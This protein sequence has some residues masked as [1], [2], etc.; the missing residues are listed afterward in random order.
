MSGILRTLCLAVFVIIFSV[1]ASF[2]QRGGGFH[3]GGGFHSGGRSFG[4]FHHGGGFATFHGG[5][6][7]SFHHGGYG[8]Y[9]SHYRGGYYPHGGHPH[10]YYGGY[11]YYYG[12]PPY[13]YGFSFGFG[14]G[15]F[16]GYWGYPS[17]YGPYP[18]PYPSYAPGYYPDG[19]SYNDQEYPSSPR[20]QVDHGRPVPR[21]PKN[22]QGRCDYRYLATCS[23]NEE[24]RPATHEQETSPEDA[25]RVYLVKDPA[26]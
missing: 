1:S 25:P 24:H 10:P 16:W 8:Y 21:P 12:Y 11:P 2:A 15:P 4:G 3:G 22:V 9:G 17:A 5:R 18:G 20:G 14:F 6:A 23:S 13:A 19:G 26:Q 7:G